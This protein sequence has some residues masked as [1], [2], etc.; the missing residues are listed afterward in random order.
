MRTYPQEIRCSICKRAFEPPSNY[1]RV[2]MYCPSCKA[3]VARQNTRRYKARVR[4]AGTTELGAEPI[5]QKKEDWFRPGQFGEINFEAEARAIAAE[6][7]R[8]FGGKRASARDTEY[9]SGHRRWQEIS[10]DM[11]EELLSSGLNVSEEFQRNRATMEAP[12]E[13][14]LERWLS[15]SKEAEE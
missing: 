14:S 15:D 2:P 10:E 12:K 11:E 7:R 8:I 9:L 1:G 5:R 6:K 4:S 3:Q 13:L